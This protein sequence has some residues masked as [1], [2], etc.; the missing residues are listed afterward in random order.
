MPVRIDEIL[1]DEKD[2]DQLIEDVLSVI[3]NDGLVPHVHADKEN[4]YIMTAFDL[5]DRNDGTNILRL[6][7]TLKMVD[8]KD[9]ELKD[10][11]VTIPNEETVVLDLYEQ[12]EDDMVIEPFYEIWNADHEGNRTYVETVNRLVRKGDIKGKNEVSLSAMTYGEMTFANDLDTINL[13]LGFKPKVYDWQ[14]AAGLGD[15]PLV[16]GLAEDFIGMGMLIGRIVSCKKIDVMIGNN[17]YPAVIARLKTGFGMMPALFGIEHAE[18]IREGRLVS[19]KAE[20]KADL[21]C[22]EYDYYKH[23][24]A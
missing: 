16:I 20:I 11:D 10:I 3:R 7:Y 23:Q 5:K 21:A 19:L 14:K 22:G 18:E 4:G 12:E 13:Q 2:R 9:I 6:I 15:E 24:R 8:E 1:A 17:S